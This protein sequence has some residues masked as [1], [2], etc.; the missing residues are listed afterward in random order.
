MYSDINELV[1]KYQHIID[2]CLACPTMS[3][4]SDFVQLIEESSKGRLH[5]INLK[6]NHGSNEGIW[7][8][9]L[10]DYD[11][12]AV[13]NDNSKNDKYIVILCNSPLFWDLSWGSFVVATTDGENRPSAHLDDQH[14]LSAVNTHIASLITQATSTDNG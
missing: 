14:S 13:N 10:S 3:D 11:A 1:E 8:L 7:A 4:Y 12:D 5:K 9:A 6:T 2:Q